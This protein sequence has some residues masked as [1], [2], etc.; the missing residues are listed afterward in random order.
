MVAAEWRMC[1]QHAGNYWTFFERLPLR[2]CAERTEGRFLFSCTLSVSGSRCFLR[3]L[4]VLMLRHHYLL[5]EG[6]GKCQTSETAWGILF[7]GL[8]PVSVSFNG[9][10]YTLRCPL[11][12]VLKSTSHVLF[13]IL[14]SQ[15][16]MNWIVCIMYYMYVMWHGKMNSINYY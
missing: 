13:Y 14:Y 6:L 11:S 4:D 10:C 16:K 1:C 7:H 9:T 2:N 12:L 5:Y 8:L 15:N 3:H